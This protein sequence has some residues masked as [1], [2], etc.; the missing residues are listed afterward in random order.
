[1]SFQESLLKEAEV[2]A[3]F[4][5]QPATLRNWRYKGEGPAFIKCGSHIRYSRSSV[6]DFIRSREVVPASKETTR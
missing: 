1:M 5:L 2:A 6:E 4:Q 3:Q